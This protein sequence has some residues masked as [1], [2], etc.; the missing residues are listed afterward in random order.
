MKEMFC[1]AA[2]TEGP[3]Q[4]PTCNVEWINGETELNLV[5]TDLEAP[6]DV[7]VDKIYYRNTLVDDSNCWNQGLYGY[8]MPLENGSEWTEY[9]TPIIQDSE[10]CHM[11]EYYAVDKLGN[12][13]PIQ[14]NCFFVDMTPPKEIK[15][16][17]DPYLECNYGEVPTTERIG[18]VYEGTLDEPI[19]GICS[20]ATAPNQCAY[21][22]SDQL[23]PYAVDTL[24]AQGVNQT[25]IDEGCGNI[26]ILSSGDPLDP[27]TDLTTA[28]GNNGCGNNPDGYDTYDCV[29]L[30]YTTAGTS[31]VLAASAEFPH[32]YSSSFTDW[33]RIGGIIDV[34]IRDWE[35]SATPPYTQTVMIPYGPTTEGTGT[36]TLSTIGQG[37]TVELR[38]A[39]SGDSV[40]DTAMIVVPLECFGE[41]DPTPPV[42]C[43]NEILEPGEEC[44]DGNT[45]NGDGCSSIC[46]LENGS[47][48]PQD[49]W[50][51]RDHVTEITLDCEDQG[52]HPV[53][54]EWVCYRIA[55][56]VPE[57]PWLTEQYCTEFG[58]TMQD[59]WCCAYVGNPVLLSDEVIAE[60]L[61]IPPEMMGG[62][63]VF[64]FTEDS[65]H[66]LEFYCMDHLG[67]ENTTIDKETFRVDS[68]PPVTTKTYL[69][70]FHEEGDV[71]W[72]DTASTIQLTAIDGG[73]ICHVD[74]VTTYYNYEMVADEN[75]WDECMPQEPAYTEPSWKTY[76]EPF[77]IPEESCHVIRYYSVDALGNTEDV[78]QQCVFVDKT[79]P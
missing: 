34:S 66:E 26:L 59:D 69:G 11:L 18:D 47:I 76:T 27:D 15:L 67:N 44:D 14:T 61:P 9:T 55:F 16:I 12:T 57:T 10:S 23:P 49:C 5:S 31:I 62:P 65:E 46:T 24:L 1:D 73:D 6:C 29:T 8:C 4:M 17:G 64:V 54:Q 75:C 25:L 79:P 58:G 53:E 63:Y 41:D 50:W 72:I 19:N 3:S 43:G 2:V 35:T 13:E 74:G 30:D 42:L 77:P 7:G 20:G 40:L 28:M 56:D 39:D 78:N 70:P 32:Y 52:D 68:I 45:D 48:P 51:V 37:Q 36:V 38:I 60:E 21:I 71:H 22:P 33:M